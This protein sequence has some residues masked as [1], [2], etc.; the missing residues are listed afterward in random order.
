MFE[1]GG[2][3]P[4]D[5]AAMMNSGR[6]DY[7]GM[8]A[9]MNN[10]FIYLAFMWM[11]RM[12][13][14]DCGNDNG[15]LMAALASQNN[16]ALTRAE[17]YD[18]LNFQTINERLGNV[19]QSLCEGFGSVNTNLL[20]GFNQGNITMLQGFNQ[21]GRDLCCG[22]N[23]VQQSIAQLGFQNQQCCCETQGLIRDLSAENYRNTCEITSAI[24]REGEATRALINANTV[25]EL[26]DRLEQRDR[27]L[28]TAN[29]Q[30]SQQAQSAN[31]ISTL[32]PTPQPA[33]LTCSPYTSV[34]VQYVA[35]Q[36]SS[37]N[38]NTCCNNGF[39]Q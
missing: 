3:S 25:Q 1:N 18:G 16:G 30:L 20:Q 17:L 34:P 24:H 14:N 6:N 8:G 33:Y 21:T 31:L 12:F 4:A 9:W 10:P 28:L 35:A 11:F 22:F 38:C 2:M 39:Y 23:G 26:R 29:F 36:Q 37:T 7:D 15:A 19:S 13:G 27:D 32:R 5:V